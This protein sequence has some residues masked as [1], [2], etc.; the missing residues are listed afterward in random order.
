M[1]N[2][3]LYLYMPC[4][5][6]LSNNIKKSGFVQAKTGMQQRYE[7]KECGRTWTGMG[8]PK[9]PVVGIPCP[10]CHGQDIARKGW[11]IT[12]QGKIQQY[13]CR[14]CG[15]IFTLKPLIKRAEP[16]PCPKCH[17]DKTRKGGKYIRNGKELQR[18]VC[19]SCHS[20]W[21]D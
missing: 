10:D 5:D 1:G 2:Y 3:I 16:T 18:Y 15:H 19:N 21:I 13:V 17:S 7:C 6:C 4:P 11:R 12:R 8:R 14:S 9:I 20:S